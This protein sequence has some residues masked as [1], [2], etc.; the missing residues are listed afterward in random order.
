MFG[1]TTSS[2]SVMSNSTLAAVREIT[3]FE[4]EH[5]QHKPPFVRAVF[6]A[7]KQRIEDKQAFVPGNEN[8][9]EKDLERFL[10]EKAL[11]E[12]SAEDSQYPFFNLGTFGTYYRSLHAVHG[13]REIC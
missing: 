8:K 6:L 2:P 13:D 11:A 10:S 12:E 9:W 5:N 7:W 1:T 4:I 3:T